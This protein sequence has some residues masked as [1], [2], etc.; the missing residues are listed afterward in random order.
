MF[1][2]LYL[3]IIKEKTFSKNNQKSCQIIELKNKPECIKLS[4]KKLFHY[5]REELPQK[6]TKYSERHFK[7]AGTDTF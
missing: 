7:N 1:T 4:R 2:E 6:C 3:Y 5:L